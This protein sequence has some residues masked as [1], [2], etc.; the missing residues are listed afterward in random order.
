VARFNPVCPSA[1][2]HPCLTED[3]EV[4][5]YNGHWYETQ[6]WNPNP[7][8]PGFLYTESYPERASGGGASV[9]Q[10]FYCTLPSLDSGSCTVTRITD[11]ASWDEQ[12]IF[13][14]DGGK[15]IFM[16]SRARDGLFNT[17]A[18]LTRTAAVPSDYDY[19]LIL[20]IFEAGFLQ[21]VGQEATDLYETSLKRP[22]TVTRLTHD[23]DN[24]WITPEFAWDPS[25]QYLMWTENRFPDG[26]RYQT[27]DGPAG[28]AQQL[29]DLAADPP[30]ASDII[31][32]NNNGVG[33]APLPLQQQTQ[34]LCFKAH[35]CPL[36]PK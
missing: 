9:P 29:Q 27:P 24:G 33:V 22:G 26:Y 17:W 14:P 7:R 20:P 34:I 8:T 11:N 5:P 2:G 13:T 16:S 1:S 4:R 36:A 30:N 25:R 32:V 35:A 6:W 18:N 12:A 31:D 10:L 19:L 23:G 21:P 15:V 28:W 3:H